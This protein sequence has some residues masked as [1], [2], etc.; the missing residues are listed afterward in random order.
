MD[1]SLTIPGTATAVVLNVTVT[2]P[3]TG[4][5]LTVFPDG[6]PLPAVSNLN[7]TAGETISNLVVVPVINGQRLRG[8][9]PGRR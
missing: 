8:N 5:F 9:R 1:L 7:F 2:G 4:G 3:A 6:Q